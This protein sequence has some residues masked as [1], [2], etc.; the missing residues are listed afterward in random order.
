MLSST[1]LKTAWNGLLL[2]K[3][4]KDDD[5]DEVDERFRTKSFK[6]QFQNF[7]KDPKKR[8]ALLIGLFLFGTLTFSSQKIRDIFGLDFGFYKKITLSVGVDNAGIREADR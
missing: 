6:E 1:K 3:D 4:K 5:D 7:W 8:A 2:N